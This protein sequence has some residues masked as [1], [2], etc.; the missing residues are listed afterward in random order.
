MT[1]AFLLA[2]GSRV[3][4]LELRPPALDTDQVEYMDFAGNIAGHGQFKRRL[5]EPLEGH[6]GPLFPF[7]MAAVVLLGAS[8]ET[9]GRAVSL[10]AGSAAAALVPLLAWRLW[11]S[12]PSVLLAAAAAALHPLSATM[13]RLVYPE[14]LQALLLAGA[15]V[16]LTARRGAGIGAG[17]FLGLAFLNRRESLL[18]L[19]VWLLLLG[20]APAD[21]FR[22]RRWKLRA[23]A[24]CLGAFV[25][26]G[27]PYLCYLRVVTGG[28]RL[29]SE[30]A[31][32]WNLGRL[33]ERSPDQPIPGAEL[34]RLEATYASPWDYFVDQP[35]ETARGLAGSTLFHARHAL[36]GWRS[37]LLGS[38]AL[39]GLVVALARGRPWAAA[40]AA[41]PFALCAA[42]SFAGPFERYSWVLGPTVALLAAALGLLLPQE[43]ISRRAR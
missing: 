40:V 16:A 4:W 13:S 9:A 19:P 22:D 5:E 24:G 41:A 3:A 1:G 23:A 12:R 18:L 20:T 27:L 10:L 7:A 38:A 25:A 34:R 39:A 36:F 8:P 42:W 32:A 33:M 17:A 29:S 14:A 31:F 11:G 26:L 37:G 28:W 15:S 6:H 21:G 2:L 30:T 43:A 35:L